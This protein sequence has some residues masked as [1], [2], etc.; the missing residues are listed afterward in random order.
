M[1]L[2]FADKQKWVAT[3]EAIVNH[4][5]KTDRQ[6]G[7][8]RQDMTSWLQSGY[9]T[10]GLKETGYQCDSKKKHLLSMWTV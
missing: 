3:L 2:S 8:V 9:G 6:K 7:A 10:K 5:G 4:S 1:A